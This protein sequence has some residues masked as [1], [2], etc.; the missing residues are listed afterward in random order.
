MTNLPTGAFVHALSASGAANPGRRRWLFVPEDQLSDRIGPLAREPATSLGI[1]LIES[2]WKAALRPWHRHRLALLWANARQFALEQARRGVAVR[3]LT[4][5][6]PFAEALAPIAAEVGTLRVMR[7]AERELRRDLAPLVARGLIEELPHEGWLTTPDDFRQAQHGPPWRMD[8]FYR[9][10]RRR[11]GVLID[12]D[13]AFTGGR[14]SFDTENRK[15]WRGSPPAPVPPDF[16]PDEITREVIDLVNAQFDRHPG[17]VDPASLPATEADARR[18]LRWAL[19]DCLPHFGPYEDA[20]SVRSRTLF[21]TRVSAL[22]NLHRLLPRDL[23]D[24]A[25]AADVPLPSR[26][27][28]VRQVLGWR[29]FVRHVHDATDGFR[30]LPG[31]P[32]ASL[33]APGDGGWSR[34]TGEPWTGPPGPPPDGGALA[35]ALQP[36]DRQTPLPAAWWGAPSG[37]R[38]LDQVVASVWDEAWSH[39]ITRL[40]VLG[41]L[42]TL[43]DCSVRDLTDWFWCAYA[44]AWDWVV[45]PNVMA[46]A[47]FG[48]G[49]LMTTKPYVAGAAY[50]DRMSDFCDGCR[51]SPKGDCPVTP[52]YWAFLARHAQRLAANQRLAMPYAS[53]ARRSPAL[54]ARDQRVYL[55]VR[56][57]L[58][59]GRAVAPADLP[60]PA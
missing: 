50:I 8:R 27:G 58:L 56:S 1:V 46:M 54:R 32:A 6:R 10:V 33:P 40:M 16:E 2:R 34:W 31:G 4:A 24:G 9:H 37:L 51:F 3:Y 48:V 38:C 20:M 14:L 53:L 30:D 41:N 28:F 23:I 60:P 11:T 15:P 29:E 43:L 36:A 57:R 59:E 25:A 19:R 39:H 49:D 26:E 18:L 52:L 21:H 42:A 5:D 44:D 17:R 7:P 13:G 35:Q 45:E 55:T 12:P 22:V 47:T